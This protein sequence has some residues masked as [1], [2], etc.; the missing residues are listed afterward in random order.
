[1]V[2]PVP[3]PELPFLGV[4]LTRRID[5]EVLIG[6]SALLAGARDA[7][8]L[9]RRA[10]RAT[11]PPRSPGPAPVAW[12]G[13]SGAPASTRPRHA[14]AGRRVRGG[15]GASSCPSCGRATCCPAFAGVRAQAVD[16]DGR[17]GRRL[18]VLAHRPRAARAQRTLARGAPRRSRSRGTS[19]TRRSVPSTYRTPPE[20]QARLR[21]RQQRRLTAEQASRRGRRQRVRVADRGGVVAQAVAVR[22]ADHATGLDGR[23]RRRRHRRDRCAGRR[24]PPAPAVATERTTTEHQSGREF[25]CGGP[26]GRWPRRSR[27]SRP[28]GR[29]GNAPS[30]DQ[31]WA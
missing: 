14:A 24:C 12:P 15:G 2:Y 19:Q 30:P 26:G 4:H 25:V 31:R 3:D 29:F 17:A 21:T 16:R 7:Y 5:G 27:G 13:A 28:C 23:R 9:R 1:M 8:S 10:T 6:P 11:S 18:R 22:G 20:E